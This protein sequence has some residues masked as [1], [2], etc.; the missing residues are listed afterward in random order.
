MAARPVGFWGGLPNRPRRLSP[1]LGHQ[2]LAAS[3]PR[4]LSQVETFPF[5]LARANQ[6]LARPPV[7][8]RASA[9]PQAPASQTPAA[10]G[11]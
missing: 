10:P 9:G 2:R 7:Q 11:E 8:T 1:Q 6:G 3:G 5:K 4:L